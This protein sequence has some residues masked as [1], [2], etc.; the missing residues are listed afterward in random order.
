MCLHYILNLLTLNRSIRASN[1]ALGA[2]AQKEKNLD[3][4]LQFQQGHFQRQMVLQELG[5]F[6]VVYE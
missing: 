5:A 4:Y 2:D 3:T 1:L 6:I